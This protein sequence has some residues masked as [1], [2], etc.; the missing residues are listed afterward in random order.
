MKVKDDMQNM[1]AQNTQANNLQAYNFINNA[2]HQI[3]TQQQ[4]NPGVQDQSNTNLNSLVN[5]Q[6]IADTAQVL[7]EEKKEPIV[8][9]S[10]IYINSSSN[11]VNSQV[12][13]VVSQQTQVC[14][15]SSGNNIN[16][17]DFNFDPFD[18]NAL[19]NLNDME[20]I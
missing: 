6:F 1:E 8:V 7:S 12:N 3:Q 9:D 16:E 20:F 14:G 13:E 4:Q 15:N 5:F 18:S 10:Q 17:Y 2:S 19:F 11:N